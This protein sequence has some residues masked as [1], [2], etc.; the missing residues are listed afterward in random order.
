MSPSPDMSYLCC[1]LLIRGLSILSYFLHFE[2]LLRLPEVLA[3]AVWAFIFQ[4]VKASIAANHISVST[5]PIRLVMQGRR[6]LATRRVNRA[7]MTLLAYLG[8]FAAR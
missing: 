7:L 6:A 1:L 8:E 5:G 2:R 4:V 3:E